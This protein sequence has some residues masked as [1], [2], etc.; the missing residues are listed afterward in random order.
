M[1]KSRIQI[2]TVL[3]LL[4]ITGCVKNKEEKDSVDVVNKSKTTIAEE[5]KLPA[6][7]KELLTAEMM[8]IQSAMQTLLPLLT[9]GNSDAADL[10]MQIHNSFILKQSLTK[11][12]LKELI[13]LLPKDFV[14][15]DRTFHADAKALADA[16]NQSDFNTAGR[17]YGKMISGCINCHSRYASKKFSGL[18]NSEIK[19]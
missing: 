8:K 7:Y 14:K 9:A 12:E 10:S 5:L 17:I 11:E 4:L 2:I 13:S 15:L 1:K 18:T 19:D 3:I 16:V 6:K